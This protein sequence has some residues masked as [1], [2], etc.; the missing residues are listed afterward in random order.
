M[1]TNKTTNT[2][3]NR[4]EVEVEVPFPSWGPKINLMRWFNLQNCG[5]ELIPLGEKVS[6]QHLDRSYKLHRTRKYVFIFEID[7]YGEWK[8]IGRKD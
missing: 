7:K 8:F 5:K 4:F 6:K 1:E 2:P 3:T